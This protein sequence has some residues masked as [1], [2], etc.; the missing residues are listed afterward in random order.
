MISCAR[1]HARARGGVR[2]E[3][4]VLVMPRLTRDEAPQIAAD[5]IGA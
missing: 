3:S 4:L 1:V 2:S 5:A